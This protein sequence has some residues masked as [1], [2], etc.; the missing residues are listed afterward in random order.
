[1]METSQANPSAEVTRWDAAQAAR[2]MGLADEPPVPAPLPHRTRIIAPAVAAAGV[3]MAIAALS[4]VIWP[5]VPH[6][7][8]ERALISGTNAS[9]GASNPDTFTGASM[10]FPQSTAALTVTLGLAV[11]PIVEAS[12]V[13]MWG[14]DSVSD[15][16]WAQG[17]DTWCGQIGPVP[18]FAA[19]PRYVSAGSG[20]S[21]A[22]LAN[23]TVVVWGP[24]AYSENDV[25]AGLPPIREVAVGGVGNGGFVVCVDTS[26]AVHCWGRNNAGQT[27][28]PQD[29]SGVSH[30]AAGG[31][32]AE[33]LLVDGTVR[34]WGEQWY[35]QCD[36]PADLP[37]ARAIAAGW[38]FSV[39]I[40]ADGTARCWGA[41]E[42]G[43]CNVPSN[44]MDV[45]GIDAGDVHAVAVRGDG[46]VACWG[47]NQNGQFDVPPGLNDVVRASAGWGH[48]VALRRDGSVVQWGAND[49]NEFK[50]L[51]VGPSRITA[52]DAGYFHTVA[53]VTPPC[54]GDIFQDDL[55]NGADLGALLSYWGPVT[56][57]PASALCDLDQDGNVNG[58]DLGLLLANWGSCGG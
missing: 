32:F 38:R 15:C 5:D 29:L 18:T 34:C 40:C 1:M 17:A 30:V 41:N 19:A 43:Q 33:A 58:A 49:Y 53:L 52:I 37:P 47:W 2:A 9:D 50:N 21:A 35:G 42:Y 39:V 23:G 6:G 51:P 24:N 57:A 31:D 46:T 44:L 55:V 13:I 10:Q 28:A 8:L 12:E 36:V 48:T 16:A 7:R 20:T 56:S 45:V 22:V 27:S 11:C 26:N 25:P 14:P 54:V 4:A 3:L